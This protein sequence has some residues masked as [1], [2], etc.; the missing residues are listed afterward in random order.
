ME[1]KIAKIEIYLVPEA[2]HERNRRLAKDIQKTLRCDWLARIKKVT[3][4]EIHHELPS[5]KERF[6]FEKPA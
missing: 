6:L 1:R 2:S 3:I 4:T 5:G